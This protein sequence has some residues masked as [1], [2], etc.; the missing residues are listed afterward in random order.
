MSMK[1]VPV[2]NLQYIYNHSVNPIDD[3]NV[4]K[5]IDAYLKDGKFYRNL[6]R[7]NTE[8]V[9]FPD[10]RDID[11]FESFLFNT[12]KNNI[13]NATQE[14]NS[15]RRIDVNDFDFIALKNALLNI[16]DVKS[17]AEVKDRIDELDYNR[18]TE[19]GMMRYG[20][21]ANGLD[22]YWRHIMSRRMKTPVNSEIDV[23]EHRLYI[24]IGREVEYDF[25]QNMMEKFSER[26]LP[27][28]FKYSNRENCSR[29]DGIVIYSDTEHLSAYIEVLNEI[30]NEH[31]EYEPYIGKPPVLSCVVDGWLGYGS[32]PSKDDG[33]NISFNEKRKEIIETAIEEGTNK[34]MYK[35][36]DKE[37]NV[38]GRRMTYKEYLVD[39]L[40]DK[41]VDK[42]REKSE[43]MT[44]NDQN[45]VRRFDSPVFRDIVK[46]RY[47]NNIDKMLKEII[48]N[49]MCSKESN[50]EVLI[51]DK[52]IST[53]N[54][55]FM[56]NIMYEEI[57]NQNVLGN[58]YC[59]FIKNEILSKCKDN[60]IDPDNFAFDLHVSDTLVKTNRVYEGVSSNRVRGFLKMFSSHDKSEVN[61]LFDIDDRV[62][63]T[64]EGQRAIK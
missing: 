29:D 48:I 14:N 55:S 30:K 25:L 39:K 1:P 44:D 17:F 28:Y 32:E 26:K 7:I 50:I 45:I 21:L 18:D 41:A 5:I 2:K 38:N 36:L 46:K 8:K 43:I 53:N 35:N 16:S 51:N 40:T 57:T 4:N 3:D 34:W 37:I 60:D 33:K 15:F 52:T 62:Q 54:N 31:R 27:Y 24:N 22:H 20:H 63:N 42:L 61:K 13:V 56:D 58:D 47:T 49:G 23:V 10:P 64:K 12:W 9:V 11:K 6:V 19:Y 59:G